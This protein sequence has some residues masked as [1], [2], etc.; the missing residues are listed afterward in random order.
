MREK[1]TEFQ[2]EGAEIYVPLGRS[3]D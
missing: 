2:D 3:A 1:S